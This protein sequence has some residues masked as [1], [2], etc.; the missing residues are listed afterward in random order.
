MEIAIPIVI[1]AAVLIFR[2]AKREG[3]LNGDSACAIVSTGAV[4]IGTLLYNLTGGRSGDICS[5]LFGSSSIVTIST[6]DVILS[7]VLSPEL[8][9]YFRCDLR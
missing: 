5:S 9:D 8:Q 2:L 3:K 1:A 4:A 7:I 6:K